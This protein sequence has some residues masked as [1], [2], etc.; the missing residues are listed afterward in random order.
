MNLPRPPRRLRVALP[1]LLSTGLVLLAGLVNVKLAAVFIGP[2]GVGQLAIAQGVIIVMSVLA[3]LGVN[4]GLIRLVSARRGRDEHTLAPRVR[5]VAW[6]ITAGAA[7]VLLALGVLLRPLLEP[8]LF[9]DEAGLAYPFALAAGVLMACSYLLLATM[10]SEGRS[11]LFAWGTGLG[12]VTTP[13]VSLPVFWSMGRSG[14]PLAVLLSATGSLTA[15]LVVYRW[16]PRHAAVAAPAGHDRAVAAELVAVGLPQMVSLLAGISAVLVLPLMVQARLGVEDTG[17]FRAG[18]GLSTA[19]GAMA[20]YIVMQEFFP[21]IAVAAAQGRRRFSEA[22]NQ[23]FQLVMVL[24]GAVVV[25]GVVGAPV[26]LRVLYSGEFVEA[27]N[28]VRWLLAAEF[29]RLAGLV[30]LNAVTA[31][32]APSPRWWWGCRARWCLRRWRGCW[33]AVSG[34]RRRGSR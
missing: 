7:S 5:F 29:L 34:C 14:V 24:M 13:L 1:S 19:A 31:A 27:S 23:Q 28:T 25:L 30:L 21:R 2:V 12:A 10:T 26:L 8:V 20:N 32:A 18:V 15:A 22:V 4:T 3:T 9:P 11:D 33:W 16:L 6:S 17:W